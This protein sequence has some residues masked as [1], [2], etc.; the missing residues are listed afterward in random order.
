MKKIR[1]TGLILSLIFGSFTLSTLSSCSEVMTNTYNVNLSFDS[2]LGNVTVDYPRGFKG[3]IFTVTINPNDGVVVK[4][5]K[6]NGEEHEIATS[7]TITAEAMTYDIVVTFENSNNPS[8]TPSTSVDTS[9]T[10]NTIFDETMGSVTVDK[11]EGADYTAQSSIV[12]LTISP[13]EGY[14]VK[15]IL[16]NGNNEDTSKSQFYFQPIK[17]ENIVQVDFAKSEG[18]VVELD[19]YSLLL[20]Y[21]KEQGTVLASETAGDLT[22]GKSIDITVTPNEGFE[23]ESV[24]FNSESLEIKAD[25]KYTITPVKGENTFGVTFKEVIEVPPVETFSVQL[26]CDKVGGSAS[27]DKT[28]G[29]VGETITLTIEPE[30]GYHVTATFNDSVIDFADGGYIVTLTPVKG[31]NKVNVKFIDPETNML[32]ELK[33]GFEVDTNY[34]TVIGKTDFSQEYFVQAFD[35]LAVLLGQDGLPDYAEAFFKNFYNTVIS[36]SAL[37]QKSFDK[38]V[39]I[40]SEESG[41]NFV[42]NI[43]IN[44]AF[45][46]TEEN[47]KNGLDLLSTIIKEVPLS[48][49]AIVF[50]CLFA[51]NFIQTIQYNSGSIDYFQGLPFNKV[52]SAIEYFKSKNDPF[53]ND[54]ASFSSSFNVNYYDEYIDTCLKEMEPYCAMG[55]SL[56]YNFIKKLLNLEPNTSILAKRIVTIY[57]IF[58]STQGEDFLTNL[59]NK[60]NEADNYE[61]FKFLGKVLYNCLPS[62]KSFNAV[63]KLL[64][65]K[66]DVF[67]TFYKISFLN[68]FYSSLC[69]YSYNGKFVMKAIA[70]KGEGLYYVLKLLGKS[71]QNA[72]IDEYRSFVTFL[73]TLAKGG[74]SEESIYTSSIRLSKML[75]RNLVE[76]GKATETIKEKFAEGFEAFGQLLSVMNGT[77]SFETKYEGVEASTYYLYIRNTAN[78]FDGFEFNKISDFITTASQYDPDTLDD[79]DVTYINNFY[80]EVMNYAGS[81][82]S[83]R[84][85]DTYE[86]T[87]NRYPKVGEDLIYDIVYPDNY[88]ASKVDF[89]NLKGFDNTKP[90]AG[91]GIVEFDDG[92]LGFGYETG[93]YNLDFYVNYNII[94]DNNEYKTSDILYLEKG[95]KFNDSEVMNINEFSGETIQQYKLSELDLNLDN[96]GL[97]FGYMLINDQRYIYFYYVYS[98]DD[99]KYE[100]SIYDDQLPQGISKYI[101]DVLAT[102]YILVDDDSGDTEKVVLDVFYISLNQSIKLDTSRLGYHTMGIKLPNNDKN[103]TIQY[104]VGEVINRKN[105]LSSPTVDYY[106]YYQNELQNDEKL[107]FYFNT[108]YEFLDED[109]YS[110]FKSETSDVIE[111][112][113]D[114]FEYKLDNSQ[115]GMHEDYYVYN[116]IRYTFNY[117]TN[118]FISGDN[119]YHYYLNSSYIKDYGFSDEGNYAEYL[120]LGFYED[121]NGNTVSHYGQDNDKTIYGINFSLLNVSTDEWTPGEFMET[122]YN[123]GGQ[124]ISLKVYLSEAVD[125]NEWHSMSPN[126][127]IIN[128]NFDED[129]LFNFNLSSEIKFYS[130]NMGNYSWMGFY[131]T[132]APLSYASIKDKL[133]LSTTGEKT[134]EYITEEGNVYDFTY[135]VVEGEEANMDET[136]YI[137]S[138]DSFKNIK[139]SNNTN[140]S[141]FY[142]IETSNNLYIDDSL[143]SGTMYRNMYEKQF[144]GDNKKYTLI[145]S[146]DSEVYLRLINYSNEGESAYFKIRPV[147]LDEVEIMYT[148]CAYEYN[149]SSKTF[150]FTCF[151]DFAYTF[152][153]GEIMYNRLYFTNEISYEKI[154][155][156]IE[157]SGSTNVEVSIR[158][159]GRTLKFNLNF[160][161]FNNL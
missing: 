91:L 65:E 7:F 122:T 2:N 149:E 16:I 118:K 36:K 160:D 125:V 100:Y 69:S 64:S 60:E 24:T 104:Y 159:G 145:S 22:E 74:T 23:V 144:N 68:N 112:S 11:T 70:D 135:K 82:T 128:C 124:E 71:L 116:G 89:T 132:L 57:N 18:P 9:F 83:N 120:K 79:E 39:S 143:Y 28:S 155:N 105:Y 133:D 108:D 5:I 76:F 77:I 130:F 8:D 134:F 129:Y 61:S 20:N 110:Q 14:Y 138:S 21:N 127:F 102:K 38:I 152:D 48:D 119:K 31:E 156:L 84:N 154:A 40:F 142:I 117:Y 67:K 66:D 78:Y 109:G 46:F 113:Q 62:L 59:E 88:V 121:E 115:F 53:A 47:V 150:L 33:K 10:V 99:V 123:N 131:K 55:A 80:N 30:P 1:K 97:N 54:L 103:V 81:N 12:T 19:K 157:E 44:S 27:L 3:D 56:L 101:S 32:E 86:F 98:K 140:E 34:T 107:Y 58:G 87:Y 96:E 114:D 94:D 25:G 26:I 35:K 158:I 6:V 151:I 141:A 45:K 146:N 111:L 37:T 51:Y 92:E 95:H 29:N 85:V 43:I 137:T 90:N 4:S 139:F 106:Y 126:E 72:T 50:H 42:N 93:N 52:N 63:F 147:T 153:D 75:V 73:H 41:I 17:G 136:Y 161:G 148:E 15:T 13:K 49:C